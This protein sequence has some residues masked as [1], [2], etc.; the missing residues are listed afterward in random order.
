[1]ASLLFEEA[2]EVVDR[3]KAELFRNIGDGERA[4]AQKPACLVESN[5][6]LILSRRQAGDLFEAMT[7]GGVADAEIASEC[8]EVDGL[9]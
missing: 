9:F 5:M 1:M 3:F 8:L 7:E 4:V 6:D 2:G